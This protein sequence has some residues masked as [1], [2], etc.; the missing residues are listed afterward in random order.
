MSKKENLKKIEILLL[1]IKACQNDPLL[2]EDYKEAV[3]ELMKERR[4]QVRRGKK[5]EEE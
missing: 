2:K 3:L 4:K 5:D 1:K